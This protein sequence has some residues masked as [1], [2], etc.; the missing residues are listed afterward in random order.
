MR[1]ESNREN[2]LVINSKLIVDS[3]KLKENGKKRGEKR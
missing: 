3:S 2:G 1:L